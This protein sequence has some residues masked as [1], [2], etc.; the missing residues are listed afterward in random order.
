MDA[1]HIKM[2]ASSSIKVH[3]FACL[4]LACVFL[5]MC[6]ISC[7][8]NQILSVVQNNVPRVGR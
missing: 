4:T 3:G 5:F 1:G 2:L 8:E 7:I 6:E